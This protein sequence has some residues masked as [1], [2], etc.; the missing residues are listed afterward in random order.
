MSL[1]YL[2]VMDVSFSMSCPCSRPSGFLGVR[3]WDAETISW[4]LYPT[5]S[6]LYVPDKVGINET[7]FRNV[8][9]F[10]ASTPASTKTSENHSD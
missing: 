7:I 1:E 2:V 10:P 4:F 8:M 6:V 3:P 9:T 5:I